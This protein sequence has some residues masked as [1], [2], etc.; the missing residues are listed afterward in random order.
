[1][2]RNGFLVLLVLLLLEKLLLVLLIVMLVAV[3][4]KGWRRRILVRL[5]QPCPSVERQRQIGWS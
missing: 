4:G 2:Q 3:F 1:M 5:L